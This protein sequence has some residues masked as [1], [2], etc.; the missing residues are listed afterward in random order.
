MIMLVIA[1]AVQGIGGGG[2]QSSVF[3][4]ISEIVAPRQRGKYQGF[5]GAVWGLSSIIGPL[6]GG[7]F[8]QFTGWRW[9][10]YINLPIGGLAIAA[11]IFFLRVP[12]R[13][14]PWR[15]TIKKVDLLGGGTLM[16]AT[17]LTLLGLEWGGR[18][19]PWNSAPVLACLII[20]FLFF[21]LF[22]YIE[23]KFAKDPV[24]PMTLFKSRN[25][26]AAQASAFFQGGVLF[27]LSFY[28]PLKFQ[29]VDGYSA[30]MAGINTLPFMLAVVFLSIGSGIIMTKTGIYVPIAQVGGVLMTV[31]LPLIGMWTPTS[32]T[33]QEIG[34]MSG[35]HGI[36]RLILA[37]FLLTLVHRSSDG[38]RGRCPPPNPHPNRASER[39]PCTNWTCNGFCRLCPNLGRRF[40]NRGVYDG[41]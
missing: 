40:R 19:Y 10:F 5:I 20:G 14:K 12:K 28:L 2:V 41:I 22:V 36:E 21:P 3:I 13:E 6:I 31:G 4:I 30:T 24:I 34:T 27:S 37:K 11:C 1:R 38:D 39:S 7:A 8:S 26:A 23:I 15:E 9:C 33:G 35:F 16:I 17:V 32:S 29:A 25:F 18:T